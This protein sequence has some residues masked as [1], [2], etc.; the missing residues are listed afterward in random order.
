MSKQPTILVHLRPAERADFL[1]PELETELQALAGEVEI[2]TAAEPTAAE[3][4]QRL[5]ALRPEV[6]LAGWGTPLVPLPTPEYLRY[7]CYMGGS[8]KN[9]VARAHL[10]AGL[11]VTN[12]GDSVSRTV[13]EHALFLVLAALRQA[14]HWGEVLHHEKGWGAETQRPGSLFGRTVGVYGFG[15]IARDFV[16]L[17]QPFGCRVTAFA[18]WMPA[19]LL[20]EHGVSRSESLDALFED[21]EI[22]VNV[23]PLND[24]SRDS[25]GEAQLRRLRD[26]G[27][28]VNVGRGHTVDE[29]ALATVAGKGR[30]HVGLDVYRDEPLP[31]ESPLRGLRNVMLTPHIAGPTPDRRRDAGAFALR[32]LR[33]YCTGEPLKALVTTE[34]FD[35][36][37]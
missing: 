36:S 9:V 24:Q 27:V 10:E 25:V 18:P 8:V 12:W 30:I 13:A 1:P 16:R 6:L 3:L 2:W 29:A 26:G 34:I 15:C 32:N 20:A 37:T 17:L 14:A 31:P 35:L 4:A 11:P 23:S 28:F 22:V 33:A 21:C 19:A 5:E 7:V